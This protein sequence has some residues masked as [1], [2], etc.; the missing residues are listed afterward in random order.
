MQ[1]ILAG[2]NVDAD[3]LAELK[4]DEIRDDL[5]PETLS[6][7]YARISRNPKPVNELRSLARQE[8]AKARR[9]NR[10]IIFSMGHHSVAEHAVFN[11]DILDISRLAIEEIEHFRLCSFTEKSQRYIKLKDDYVI[12]TEIQ[13]TPFEKDF[14]ALIHT[15]NE[16]YLKFYTSLQDA[17]L[18][19]YRSQDPDKELKRA[20]KMRANEDARYV[21]SLA[22]RGQ[23]GMTVNARN[24][25][26]VLR[27]FASHDNG[28]IQDIGQRIYTC[29]NQIA[30][31]IVLFT[32][33]NPYDQQVYKE[34]KEFADTVIS[35]H[36][37]TDIPDVTLLGYTENADR[38]LM[39]ALL[40]RVHHQPFEICQKEVEKLSLE[41]CR[42]LI[43]KTF[44]HVE[45][46]DTVLREFEFINLHFELVVSAACFAQLKRHRMATVCPQDYHPELGARI[47]PSIQEL[48]LTADFQQIMH[49]SEKYYHTLRKH[50]PSSA[51]YVLTNAHR[52]R[53]HFGCNARELY[54]ISRLREDHYA[55]W[56]IRDISLRMSKSAAKVM[57]LTTMF[58]CG[59]DHY[60]SLYQEIFGHPPKVI[61]PELPGE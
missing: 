29:V 40:H 58:L 39:A 21:L 56:D 37:G 34:L 59:K 31:S 10:N 54:H 13:G 6:A 28:E 17:Y 42:S 19:K 23:L 7:A 16:A 27:R 14:H 38:V 35:H 9:S 32:E 24:L 55:Q 61:Q 53:V 25:E 1:I 50:Y 33:S 30:P 41:Q 11:F 49:Q 22:T 26:L 5:T 15:Q 60:P 45:L 3:V 4:G 57:P 46:Y 2:F 44:E 51:P 18:V 47:P 12:P 20:A 52:R 48:G 8:V 43:M 36:S